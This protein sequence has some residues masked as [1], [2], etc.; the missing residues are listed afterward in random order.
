MTRDIKNILK[1]SAPQD[2][3]KYIWYLCVEQK[4]LQWTCGE[5]TAE[6][7]LRGLSEKTTMVVP[8]SKMM[9]K[10]LDHAVLTH[11]LRSQMNVKVE[12]ATPI[13]TLAKQS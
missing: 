12:R 9:P 7:A 8:V 2:E 11:T 3:D 10:L 13:Q 6:A 5:T 4:P 1:M